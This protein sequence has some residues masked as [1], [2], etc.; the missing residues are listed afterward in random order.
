MYMPPMYPLLRKLPDNALQQN[1]GENQERGGHGIQE[2]G[3]NPGRQCKEVPGWELYSRPK[4]QPLQTGAGEWRVPGGCLWE[5]NGGRGW[6]PGRGSM[7]E[8]LEDKREDMLKAHHSFVNKKK[9]RQL[10]TLRKIKS[11][12]RK[13]RSKMKP[14]E[15]WHDFKQLTE[16]KKNHL[17]LTAEHFFLRGPRL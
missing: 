10:E 8:K 1:K 11:C 6:T 4:E 14:T 15:I 7:T 17:T 12:V 9:E 2:T 13:L 3:S 5:E 16:C